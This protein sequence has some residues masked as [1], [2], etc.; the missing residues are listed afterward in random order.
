MRGI[1][2][3]M[4]PK[5]S[6]DTEED[7]LFAARNMN[8]SGKMIHKMVC[9]K[10]VVCGKWHVGRTWKEITEKDIAHAKK[11]LNK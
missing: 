6:F 4:R 5:K 7:A 9:Y 2:G 10:C 3:S 11:M 8:A 1:D